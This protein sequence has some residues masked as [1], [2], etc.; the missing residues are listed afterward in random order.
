MPRPGGETLQKTVAHDHKVTDHAVEAA[1]K[2]GAAAVVNDS[3]T[4]VREVVETADTI[5]K[6][7]GYGPML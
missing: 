5:G 4:D 6:P 7:A 1:M 3:E 2:T